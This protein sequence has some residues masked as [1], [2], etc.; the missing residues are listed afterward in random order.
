MPGRV[1]LEEPMSINT[2]TVRTSS[3]LHSSPTMPVFLVCLVLGSIPFFPLAAADQKPAVEEVFPVVILD[4][5][6]EGEHA[7]HK[8]LIRE[9][10]RQAFLLTAREEF[11]TPTRDITLREVTNSKNPHQH[12]FRLQV[13]LPEPFHVKVRLEA[14]PLDG[15]D[16]DKKPAGGSVDPWVAEF[17]GWEE[18]Q[19]EAALTQ[20]DGWTQHEF[21]DWLKAA[22]IPVVPVT[23][24]A[25]DIDLDAV[26]PLEF[27][28]QV[29]VLRALHAALLHDPQ[30]PV[31]LSKVIE[32]YA[33]LGS[34]TEIHWGSEQKVFKARS[35]LYAQ[36][37]VRL[38]PQHAGIAWSRSLAQAMCGRDDLAVKEIERAKSL[39]QSD[40][41]P[42]WAEA[43]AQFVTWDEAGLARSVADAQPLAPYFGL[44]AAQMVGTADQR[45][46]AVNEVMRN[47]PE[48]FRAAAIMASE[49]QI[50]LQRSVGGTQFSQFLISFP[51]DVL[52][53]PHLPQNIVDVAKTISEESS[54][55]DKINNTVKLVAALHQTPVT[56]DHAEPSLSLLGTLAGN[57][58]FVHSVQILHTQQWSL[59]IDTAS[60]RPLFATLLRDHPAKDFVQVFQSDS[61]KAQAAYIAIA[62][63]LLKLPVTQASWPMIRRLAWLRSS[64]H[65]K[66]E[67]LI[68]AE[69]DDV[70]PDL[71]ARLQDNRST[72]EMEGTLRIVEKLSPSCPGVIVSTIK[73][74]W[75]KAEPLARDWEEKSSN[76][77]VLQTLGEK[78]ESLADENKDYQEAAERCWKKLVKVE[79]SYGS[80]K[81]LANHYKKL[82]NFER[83]EEVQLE[84]LELPSFGLDDTHVHVDLA[85]WYMQ[86]H[87]YAKARPHALLAAESYS[88]W[89]LMCGARCMEGLGE[90]EEAEKFV[91][92]N[93]QRYD[94]AW[95]E[96]YLWCQRT[97]RG[98]LEAAR[99][100]CYDAVAALSPRQKEFS[101]ELGIFELL[102]EH[103]DE[104]LIPFQK[105]AA[106]RD[107]TGYY[108]IHAALLLDQ[109]GRIAERDK[110]IDQAIN[111]P[112]Q[113]FSVYLAEQIKRPLDSANPPLSRP[114]LEFCFNDSVFSDNGTNTAY[115]IGKLL[116]LRDREP[117]AIEWL[118]RAAS[119]PETNKWNCVLATCELR[120]RNIEIAPK[121]ESVLAPEFISPMRQIHSM[122]NLRQHN[123]QRDAAARLAQEI[124]AVTPDWSLAQYACAHALMRAGKYQQ[125]DELFTKLLTEMPGH[126]LFLAD[127]G[128]VRQAL[129]DQMG[130]RNDLEAA[131]KLVPNYRAAITRLKSLDLNSKQ[132]SDKTKK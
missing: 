25:P 47:S 60:M 2:T 42:D 63:A 57:L 126:P 65:Q 28:A 73:L 41:T 52:L 62:P 46:R 55:A 23:G 43:L 108:A 27:V 86:H 37:A 96:W 74:D 44:L 124:L 22:E 102:E 48:C 40:A 112:G 75:K 58:H 129:N 113:P 34:L 67:N 45:I 33:L 110:L 70:V 15:S 6:A 71:L 104:A 13:D 91:R 94:T 68:R 118:Q 64:E 90:W 122:V 10:I 103:P 95:L 106:A 132:P 35:L 4:A 115:F 11:H 72:G 26:V 88:A 54:A 105:L 69:R 127:R 125:A 29:T 76:P 17:K 87:H 121:R 78:Y 39:G 66:L 18:K 16:G 123:N 116:L 97:G 56:V 101:E 120:R 111:R 93:S 99:R 83:W 109:K 14:A 8:L 1:I 9:V 61:S 79:P 89:G 20:A 82:E 117:E 21:V 30:S 77:V 3:S 92:A 12:V 85:D 59:G 5:P 51:A 38:H 81:F 53:I 114:Q 31:L 36:R 32:H 131:L 7:C 130:A 107:N 100:Y 98:D 24:D 128:G 80:Y 50:G 49:N 19:L 119:S 84:S